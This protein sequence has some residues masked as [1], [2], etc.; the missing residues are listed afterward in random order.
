MFL[1]IT[2]GSGSGKSEYGEERAVSLAQGAP[3]LYVA[4]MEP[5]SEEARE[6]IARH[7]AMREGK[8]FVTIEQY[9]DIGNLIVPKEAT[10]L[11]ECMSNLLANEMYADTKREREEIPIWKRLSKEVAGLGKRCRN[12]IVITNEVFSDGVDYEEETERYIQYL[13]NINA[14]LFY[15]ADEVYEA[16]YGIPVLLKK[17]GN[18]NK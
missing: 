11:L 17:K 15:N 14:E 7:R 1:V 3:L 9:R 18:G 12:L 8:G 16:V 4:A 5:F 6:R 2:G 10:V 13:A